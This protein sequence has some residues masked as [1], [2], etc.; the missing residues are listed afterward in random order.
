LPNCFQ[1]ASLPGFPSAETQ[2][3]FLCIKFDKADSLRYAFLFAGGLGVET[4]RFGHDDVDG[5]LVTQAG[6]KKLSVTATRR[7]VNKPPS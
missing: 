5:L 2:D 3:V 4:V 7:S 6:K 1:I